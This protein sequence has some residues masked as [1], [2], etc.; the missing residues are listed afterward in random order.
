MMPRLLAAKAVMIR[1]KAAALFSQLHRQA[2]VLCRHDSLSEEPRRCHRLACSC[3]A[4]A[5][6]WRARR[7]FTRIPWSAGEVWSQDFLNLCRVVSSHWQ[8]ITV[9]LQPQQSVISTVVLCMLVS[10]ATNTRLLL[11]YRWRFNSRLD[12]KGEQWKLFFLIYRKILQ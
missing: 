4:R 3:P 8:T 10:L 9:A 1:T 7:L 6:P 11:P 2:A 12:F 5:A